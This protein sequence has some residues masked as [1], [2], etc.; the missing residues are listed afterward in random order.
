MRVALLLFFA[1]PLWGNENCL[2]HFATLSEEVDQRA[3]IRE[4]YFG[5][6]DTQTKPLDRATIEEILASKDPFEIPEK[7]G[8]DRQSLRQHLG[9]LMKMMKAKGWYDAQ[10]N[11]D[12]L[13]ELRRRKDGQTNAAEKLEQSL[14]NQG[15]REIVFPHIR[16]PVW[17]PDGRFLVGAADDAGT[18]F[19]TAAR[20]ILTVE[21]A[22]GKTTEL[23]Q[24]GYRPQGFTPD[25]KNVVF[26]ET[27]GRI[28][29]APFSQGALNWRAKRTL[30]ESTGE[31]A[32][33]DKA[34]V[35][36]A[37]DRAFAS[38]G[39]DQKAYWFDLATGERKPLRLA[40]G[41]PLELP[42]SW[43]FLP[44]T[45]R[46]YAIAPGDSQIH[47]YDVDATGVATGDRPYSFMTTI[48]TTVA[49][50]ADGR[51]A[52]AGGGPGEGPILYVHN[53]KELTKLTAALRAAGATAS[54]SELAYDPIAQEFVAILRER[55]GERAFRIDA[56]T[57]AVKG[58]F[59]L[60][61]QGMNFR[62]SPD[63]TRAYHSGPMGS[64]TRW[65]LN[66]ERW[67]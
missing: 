34:K 7:D 39:M 23:S 24:S 43:G 13:A 52:V 37:G 6:L 59:P 63:G 27:G 12:I 58:S 42:V 32:A 4:A 21:V 29:L 64:D 46:I 5:L 56:K 35:T 66:P 26:M 22:T 65:V 11:Q 15:D 10:V 50:G 8:V 62:F 25:G 3:A 67:R 61:G 57:L 41:R 1:V 51:V 54:V 55:S 44:G 60:N 16:E 40:D 45:E 48:Q 28:V 18:K 19:G 49:W 47:I 2:R 38:L 36:P 33:L 9:E 53:G 30:G 20:R 17:S 14:E 31:T